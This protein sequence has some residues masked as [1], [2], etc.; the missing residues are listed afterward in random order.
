MSKSLISSFGEQCEWI[1]QVAHQKWAMWAN[2]SGRSPKMSNHERFAQVTQ[3]KWAIVSESLRSLIK[4]KHMSESLIFLSK[5]LIHSFL[6]KKNEWFTHTLFFE[7]WCKQIAQVLMTK[8]QLWAN[9]S[10]R[11]PKMSDCEQF[12]KIKWATFSDSLRFAH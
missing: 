6:G 1:A 4:N 9:R 7:E 12:D 2:R 8:E 11:S 10:G 5:L 3:R